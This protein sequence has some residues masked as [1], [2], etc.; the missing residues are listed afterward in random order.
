MTFVA[1]KVTVAYCF[2]TNFIKMQN[3]ENVIITSALNNN[4]CFLLS[5][6]KL[7]N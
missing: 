1:K 4:K 6:D 5:S 7:H 2:G 3:L